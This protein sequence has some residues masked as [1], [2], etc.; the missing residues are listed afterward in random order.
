MARPRARGAERD[1]SGTSLLEPTAGVILV[2][3]G[4]P[5]G[6][7]PW[8]AKSGRR[9]LPSL[10][11]DG[12]PRP[13][14]AER[15]VFH[16]AIQWF[17][18]IGNE[19]F[20]PVSPNE[21]RKKAALGEI[22]PNTLLRKGPDGRWVRAEKVQDLFQRATPP[23]S[24]SLGESPPIPPPIPESGALVNEESE[25][26]E[27][28]LPVTWAAVIVGSGAVL[29][30]LWALVFR[31]GSE[32]RQSAEKGASAP[33][34]QPLLPQSSETPTQPELADQ[35]ASDAKQRLSDTNEEFSASELYK[36]TSPCSIRVENYD[37]NGKLAASGSGFL[38]SPDGQ[39]VTNLHVIRGAD[40][41]T[42]R[43][44]SGAKKAV[45]GVLRLDKAHDLAVLD[46]DGSGHDYLQLSAAK[47]AVG[48]RVYAIGNPLGLTG[49]LSEGVVSGYPKL[50]GVL[51][52][53]TTA[54]ISRGSSGGPLLSADG[55]VV[56]ITTAYLRGGQNLNLAV[57]ASTINSLL[58]EKQQPLTLAQVNARIGAENQQITTE[59]DP[60]KLAAVWDAIRA[61]KS[62]DALRM[63]AQI[64]S[65]RRGTGYWI[66]SGHLHFR[67][68]NLGKAQAAFGKAVA[69]DPNNTES[70]LRLALALRLDD[71]RKSSNAWDA[72][73]DLCK[74]V[75]QLDPT[76]VAAHMICGICMMPGEE[77][78]YFKTAA[79]LD[80][81]DFSAQYNLG[82]AMLCDHKVS[83]DAWKPLQEAL[84]L[85]KKIKLDDY[86]V[87]DS[88]YPV[89]KLTKM[90][91]SKSLHVP[92]KLALA[93]AYR[94][95]DQYERAIK[96]YKE[97]LALEPNNPVAEWGLCFTYRGW[98]KDFKH[99]DAVLWESRAK[100]T[101]FMPAASTAFHMPT[102]V[103]NYFGMLR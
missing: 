4:C 68:Q 30:L 20:G 59:D 46:I 98:R 79:A 93:K 61:D 76:N 8:R 72:P 71:S 26:P 57:P 12:S 89:S 21:L 67:L 9:L 29:L 70:L 19:V 60:V 62:G 17:F 75:M 25:E 97:V 80:P 39:V 77:I 47:P 27:W 83:R 10:S 82:V 91:T 64:P 16:M 13:G 5:H 86:L 31:G 7:A 45:R 48:T 55:T 84:K 65:E 69:N 34:R 37:R 99:P 41:A 51:Y 3:A 81:K 102:I 44:S 96:E 42:V 15:Q 2:N 54:A 103:Y 14:L 50:D 85:E 6:V 74:K 24:P 101:D 92:I 78:G 87:Y 63:L 11:F 18:Q 100:G 40:T 58:N 33:A 66:A 28:L 95:S 53:Q 73:R 1:F 32:P 38:V 22:L 23:P 35:G 56:G 94:D 36:R 49:T 52:I 43:L 88:L 90:P